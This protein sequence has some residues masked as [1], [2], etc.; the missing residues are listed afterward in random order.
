MTGMSKKR[1]TGK[2][3]GLQRSVSR[4]GPVGSWLL[5]DSPEESRIFW[6][7]LMPMRTSRIKRVP[8]KTTQG[9]GSEQHE[10]DNDSVM[11]TNK[12]FLA[13]LLG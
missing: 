6:R 13:M 12:V 3:S 10:L 8:W 1:R 4:L 5:L 9:I 11:A 2:L 7:K